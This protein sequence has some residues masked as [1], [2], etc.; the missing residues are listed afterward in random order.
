MI[1]RWNKRQ[2]GAPPR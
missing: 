2:L 1:N